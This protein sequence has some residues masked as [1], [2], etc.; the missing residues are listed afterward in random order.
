MKFDDFCTGFLAMIE[1]FINV[2]NICLFLII[3]IVNDVFNVVEI[4]GYYLRN[5]IV[6][7]DDIIVII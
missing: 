1:Q 2:E 4:H 3:I 6:I 7:E 5:L